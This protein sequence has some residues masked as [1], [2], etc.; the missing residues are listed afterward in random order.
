MEGLTSSNN[1]SGHLNSVRE[2]S[3]AQVLVGATLGCTIGLSTA[4]H[5]VFGLFLIPL[6][7]EFGWSRTA[8][9]GGLALLAFLSIFICPI[10]GRIADSVGPWRVAFTGVFFFAAVMAGGSLLT[11]QL[12]EWYVFYLMIAIGAPMVGCSLF[13][14]MVSETHK[15]DFGFAVGI[16]AGVGTGTGGIVMPILAAV[17]MAEFG[18]RATYLGIGISILIVGLLAMSLLKTVGKRPKL[19]DLDDHQA[20]LPIADIFKRSDFWLISVCFAFTVGVSMAIVGHIVPI[21]AERNVGVTVA[22][23]AIVAQAIASGTTQPSLGWLLDRFGLRILPPLF[24]ANVISIALFCYTADPTLCILAGASLGI[25]I[26]MQFCAIPF[27]VNLRFG[28]QS[29]GSV[30]GL[31]YAAIFLGEGIGPLLLDVVYDNAGTYFPALLAILIMMAIA[32]LWSTALSRLIPSDN[33]STAQ[34]LPA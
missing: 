18:W 11:G 32:L 34:L 24:L 7:S 17:M 20:A 1:V 22:T 10:I 12:W 15:K 19:A 9:S 2:K 6:S 21:L 4:I 25:G 13:L 8:I 33:S 31:M 14:Q 30:M 16:S 23:A 27:L 28:L 3:R 5:S 26:G 29:F